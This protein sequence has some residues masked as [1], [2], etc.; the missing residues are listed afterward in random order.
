MNVKPTGIKD[1]VVIEPRIFKDDRGYFFESYNEDL[2]RSKGIENR[3]VQDNQSASEFG[4]LRGLHYQCGEHAQAKLVRV[5]QG[6]VQ[7]VAIDLRPDSP[8]FG[9]YHSV[10]LSDENQLQFFIPKGFAHGFLVL[11]ESAIFSYKCDAFYNKESEGGLIY[12]DP[13][14]NIQWELKQ[15]DLILSEKD[16]QL[17][18]L[19]HHRKIYPE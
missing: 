15:E 14:I 12:N 1:L 8:T 10:I 17:P 5:V 13:N 3:F 19:D 16:Q 6:K 2:F 18:T 9:Q 4:V 7:D 11:S